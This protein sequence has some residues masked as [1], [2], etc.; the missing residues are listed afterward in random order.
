MLAGLHRSYLFEGLDADESLLWGLRGG[1]GNFGVVTGFIFDLHPVS[2][3]LDGGAPNM[4]RNCFRGGLVA[5]IASV[6]AVSE[7]PA[8]LSMPGRDVNFAADGQTDGVRG[9]YR[10]D[11][12]TRLAR[13][14]REYDPGNLFHRNQNVQPGP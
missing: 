8:P 4:L 1:G 7:A 5:D 13:L 6:R 12:Y 14:K 9:A 2:T 11:I 3:I 10:D